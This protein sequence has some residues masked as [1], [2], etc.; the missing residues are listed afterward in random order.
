MKQFIRDYL[1]FNKR[2]RNGLFVLL[3]IIVILLIYLIISDK[4]IST[5]KVDFTK[6]EKEIEK[7]NF[8]LKKLNDTLKKTNEILFLST[9]TEPEKIIITENIEITQPEYFNFNPNNLAEK[10]WTRLGLKNEQIQTIKNY[11]KKGGEFRINEDVKK[12]Y[13]ISEKEFKLLEPYIQIPK[14]SFKLKE[15]KITKSENN[16]PKIAPAIVELNMADSAQLTNIKGI[17]S[18]F[19]KSI[20]KYRNSLGGFVA[21]V[22]LMEIWKFDFDKFEEIEKF[23][24]VDPTKIK[25]INI[26]TCKV[27]ELKHPYLNWNTANAIINYRINHGRYK[28]LEDIK[29]TDLVDDETYRKIVPYLLLE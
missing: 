29:K 26:N 24:K 25:P 6:F 4:F 3:S 9:K 20:I 10:D 17:G 14:E 13:S 12:I 21:K 23:I 19:A 11:E 2:E 28:T 1:T 8:E 16:F 27:E 22:Q 18:F 5:E 7:H 15:F